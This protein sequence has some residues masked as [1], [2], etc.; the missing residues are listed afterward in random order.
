MKKVFNNTAIKF[1][2]TGTLIFA[3]AMLFV[4]C[5]KD[6]T[7]DNSISDD[8]VAVAIT[9][10][11]SAS[12]GGLVTQT[13]TSAELARTTTL[14]CGASSDTTISGQNAA[15]AAI[16]YN[17]NLAFNRSLICESGI[18]SQ[19]NANFNGSSSYTALRM[20]SDDNSN[21]Q[22]QITGLQPAAS[23]YTIN[24]AY[25]RS[26]TQ[27]S[28]VRFQRSFQSTISINSTN[29]VVDKASGKISSGSA[30]VSFAGSASGGYSTTRGGTISFLGAG[31]A[32]LTLD[33][34]SVF[35]IQW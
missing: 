34:G 9:E 16:T 22:L 6:D 1:I 2:R 31:Q 8:E 5:K 35:N 3:S 7:T 24:E 26:G 11:V 12:S 13:E 29:I 32:T 15:G 23:S 17:Y 25:T 4:S 10:S 27:Q 20:S 28:T 19:F 33:N 21:A 30:T 18:P 14:T